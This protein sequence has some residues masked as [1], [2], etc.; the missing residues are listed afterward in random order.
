MDL[1]FSLIFFY[2]PK[3]NL[4]K[5]KIPYTIKN[6]TITMTIDTP[7]Q[8]KNLILPLLAFLVD[9]DW[10]DQVESEGEQGDYS[11]LD[12]LGGCGSEN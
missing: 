10:E 11:I 2:P 1:V 6:H 7:K 3:N 5:S 4:N 12:I 8:Y 9:Q